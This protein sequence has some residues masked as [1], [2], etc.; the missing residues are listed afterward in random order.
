MTRTRRLAVAA[1]AF[2]A[3]ALFVTIA[4]HVAVRQLQSRL[5]TALGPRASIGAINPGWTGIEVLDLRIKAAP[6]WP[7]QDELRAKRVRIVPDLRSLFGGLWRIASVRVEEGYLSVLRARDGRMRVLP[8]LLADQPP[9]RDAA[10]GDASPPAALLEI[11]R[12]ELDAARLDFFD[13]SVRQ[14]ALQLRI[15][16]LD[17]EVGPL[18]VPALDQSASVK[19][20]G[21]F[22][23]P[24]RDGRLTIEGSFTPATRDADLRARFIGVDM[25]ALQAYLVKV[26][27]A[28]IRRGTLDLD[29]HATVFR[30]KLHA[31]G[32]L[33]LT[34]L[35]LAGDGVLGTFAGV[36]RKAVLAA[37]TE[38]GRLEVK[39]ALDGRLDD[40]SFSLNEN[41]ATKVGAG[42]AEGL[43]VS[44]SGVVKGL[45]GV[46]RGLFGR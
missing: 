12:I 36:P 28:G 33:T 40:P 15:G 7:A 39:F 42:L 17:A 24:Q 44:L 21:V 16:E 14:P 30:N 9:P 43:G 11:G 37:L 34:N 45:G 8:A 19:L 23:G 27:E 25:V 1:A 2:V 32:K 18:T 5:E 22:H 38:K 35:E 26:A 3:L 4:L 10:K 20:A 13:G 46:V 6:G 41:L 31:P 29:V